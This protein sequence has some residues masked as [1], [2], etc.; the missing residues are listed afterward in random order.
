[1]T[2]LPH[3]CVD[4]ALLEGCTCC[5]HDRQSTASSTLDVKMTEEQLTIGELAH[6]TGVATSALRYWER[7]GLI[8]SPV[9]VSGQRRYPPSA[10][11]LVG[12]ILLL[13]DLGYLLRELRA[14]LASRSPGAADWRELHQLKL[15]ELDRRIAQA[16]TARTAIAHALACPHEDI[17]MCPNYASVVAARL[18]GSSLAEAHP[19]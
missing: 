10:V 7:L 2:E 19:H 8:A 16:Q 17:R 18:A 11:D 14:L 5:R 6:R 15:T 1:V 13:R 3:Y 12:E 9:R 4:R